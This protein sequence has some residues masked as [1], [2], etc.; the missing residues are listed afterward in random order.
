MGCNCGKRKAISGNSGRHVVK[1]TNG[2]V[3]KSTTSKPAAKTIR[4]IIRRATR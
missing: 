1:P 4:R 3:G 2:T